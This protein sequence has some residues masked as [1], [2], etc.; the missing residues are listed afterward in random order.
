MHVYITPEPGNPVLRELYR[1]IIPD[2]DLFPPQHTSPLPREHTMYAAI[3]GT[4]CYSNTTI[5]S[6]QV[7]IFYG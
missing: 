5:T 3:K 1:I 2:S 6:C 7:L 4:K